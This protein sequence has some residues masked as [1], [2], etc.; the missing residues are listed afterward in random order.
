MV[1]LCREMA[2]I[3][4]QFYSCLNTS[5]FEVLTCCTT[6]MVSDLDADQYL[7]AQFT[8]SVEDSFRLQRVVN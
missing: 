4:G 7:N 1:L 2:H 3:C 6:V 5:C 8:D